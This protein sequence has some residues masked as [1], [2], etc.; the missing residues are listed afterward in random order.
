VLQVDHN[1]R[2]AR[3][4]MLAT[5]SRDHALDDRVRNGRTRSFIRIYLL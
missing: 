5:V 1:E 3:E 2:G 4:V